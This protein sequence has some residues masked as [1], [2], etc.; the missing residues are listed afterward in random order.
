MKCKSRQFKRAILTI[1]VMALT[2]INTITYAQDIHITQ[3]T[4]WSTNQNPTGNVFI[5]NGATLTIAA[6][7]TVTMPSYGYIIVKEE[8]KLIASD[9]TFTGPPNW[10]GI[11]AH[12]YGNTID[13]VS[14]LNPNGEHQPEIILEK[15]TL[16]YMQYG[17]NNADHLFSIPPVASSGGILRIKNCVFNDCGIGVRI[18]YYHHVRTQ[19]NNYARELS[20]VY[21]S[22]FI[23]NSYIAYPQ[24][25][26][27]MEDVIGVRVYGN[28]FSS[29]SKTM[30]GVRAENATFS[31]DDYYTGI[32]FNPVFVSSSKFENCLNS[33]KVDGSNALL[34]KCLIRNT[35]FIN[36][37]VAINA[38]N[39]DNIEIYSNTV[40]IDQTGSSPYNGKQ[41]GIYF[42]N[43]ATF[44]CEDNIVSTKLNIPSVSVDKT[45]GIVINN[46]GEN[47]NRIYRNT[48]NNCGYNIDGQEHN[49]GSLPQTGLQYICNDLIQTNPVSTDNTY[50]MA[51][52]T[53]QPANSLYGINDWQCGGAFD[54]TSNTFYPNS[55]AYNNIPNRLLPTGAKNDFYNEHI[56]LPYD[57]HYKNPVNKYPLSQVLESNTLNPTYEFYGD[58]IY[59]VDEFQSFQNQCP[60]QVPSMFP[61]PSTLSAISAQL[62]SVKISYQQL[63]STFAAYEN[64]G[65]YQF[66]LDQVNNL[67]NTNYT[68]VY[69]YLMNYHPSTDI[70]AIAVA[71]DDFPNYMCADVLVTNSYGIKSQLVRDAL[72]S[73][74]NQL[75]SSQMTSIYNAAQNQSQYESYLAEM[76]TLRTQINT[77]STAKYNYYFNVYS[78]EI[79]TNEVLSTLIDNQNFYSFVSLMMYYFDLGDINMANQY[80]NAAMN[81]NEI[82]ELETINLDRLYNV[83]IIVYGQLGGDFSQLDIGEIQNLESLSE[84]NSKSGGIAKSILI[85]HFEYEYDP[86]LLETTQRSSR[87]AKSDI[88]NTSNTDN[89]LIIA[90]NPAKELIGLIVDKEITYPLKLTVYDISGKMVLNVKIDNLN[91]INVDG[92]KPGI[93]QLK[94][95][96]A[97]QKSFNEK[98][99]IQ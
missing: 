71:N 90:P 63:K 68:I 74:Q 11:Y 6:G 59:V 31:I 93:Y 83:L 32:P 81:A 67:D 96:D 18:A 2:C 34:G 15:C 94:V 88:N 4:T 42:D 61:T 39:A 23:V 65:D 5:D 87:I 73:R 86:I 50:Y 60:N 64:N 51:C 85:R 97:N 84:T 79:E 36:N 40:K 80:Y 89:S 17:V 33:V 28:Y 20:Y 53:S 57:I 45:Y 44:Y 49:R 10:F 12:G 1:I 70:I 91:T 35:E 41:V 14:N 54:A 8:C 37:V 82:S 3:N 69:Y 99:V 77:L 27:A 52:L 72:A 48:V 92:L 98:L 95:I 16:N 13:Q 29:A 43:C 78:D 7:V 26:I 30:I 75:T 76:A 25:G 58:Y 56:R 62:Q 55:S 46:C 66:M 21:N 24:Y 38:L 19:N 47:N 9:A 22:K